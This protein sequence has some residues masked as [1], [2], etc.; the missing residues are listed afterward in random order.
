MSGVGLMFSLSPAEAP[1]DMSS[2][3]PL[4][5]STASI[6]ISQ[7]APIRIHHLTES[8]CA[9]ERALC[10]W[11]P[12]AADDALVL[13]SRSSAD[14]AAFQRALARDPALAAQ[15]IAVAGAGLFAP[16]ASI[17]TVP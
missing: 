4:G 2:V 16:R 10:R 17:L 6:S 5:R 12:E 15:V 7:T 9:D 8:L 1:R 11:L 3:S 13:C 14:A